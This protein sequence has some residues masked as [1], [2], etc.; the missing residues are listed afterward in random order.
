MPRTRQL[1]HDFF[2]DEQL[3]GMDPYARL[4]FAGLWLLAD[5][6]GRL[7]DRPA[8]IKAQLFPYENIDMEQML[9]ILACGFIR[10]YSV[11]GDKYIEIKDFKIHQHIH[12][13]E[14]DSVFPSAPAE[15]KKTLKNIDKKSKPGNPRAKP[16][17]TGLNRI[18][19]GISGATGGIPPVVFSPLSVVSNPV[20]YSPSEVVEPSAQKPT[21]V[22][23]V[24]DVKKP[25]TPV[26]R[27]VEAYKHAKGVLMDDRSWD[28]ANF[29]RYSKAAKSLLT[30]F[31]Q[32]VDKSA[33]YIF[34]RAE[35]LNASDLD[36]TLETITRH[37][38]D[39]I[40]IPK[41]EENHGP[42]NS[43]VGADRLDGQR[44][45]GIT[46]SSGAT[47]RDTLRLIESSAIRAKESADMGEDGHDS[48]ID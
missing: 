42:Q 5:R 10:R 2:L 11:K 13:D 36:W 39:G 14:K 1:K 37:A 31:A 7:E 9:L 23:S 32:D 43:T 6:E 41:K 28:K 8:K 47:A 48:P 22:A 35:D 20:A 44:R 26:Q 40:G 34:L 4:T 21:V 38:Y 18:K 16:D 45:T 12:R 33:A 24:Q 19:P 29:G 17:K 3:S 46:A 15:K 25:K 27:V 30:C